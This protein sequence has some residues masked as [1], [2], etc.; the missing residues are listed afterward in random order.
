MMTTEQKKLGQRVRTERKRRRLKIEELAEMA[1]VTKNTVGNFERGMSFPQRSNLDQI[2]RVLNISVEPEEES[3][4]PTVE[5]GGWSGDVRIALNVIG[6][7]L[8][9]YP[10]G[11]ERDAHIDALVKAAVTRSL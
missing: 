10:P 3:G 9:S 5:D 8:E 4:R 2:L 1:G 11:P 7:Y 6:L